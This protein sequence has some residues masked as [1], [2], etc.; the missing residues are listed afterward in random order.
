MSKHCLFDRHCRRQNRTNLW[1]HEGW[2]TP[3]PHDDG[4]FPGLERASQKYLKR[5]VVKVKLSSYC[6]N[7]QMQLRQGGRAAAMQRVLVWLLEDEVIL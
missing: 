1:I 4:P 5:A 3:E 6:P 2:E 7:L